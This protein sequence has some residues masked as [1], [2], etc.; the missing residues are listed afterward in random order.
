[1]ASEEAREGRLY[2]G[3]RRLAAVR[4]PLVAAVNGVALGGGCELALMCDVVLAS[5]DAEFG[6]V[7]GRPARAESLF[8][9]E[10][11]LIRARG[12]LFCAP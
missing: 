11:R 3:W 9:P 6:L 8:P 5:E 10:K 4:M 2:Q 7:R 12:P 1:M